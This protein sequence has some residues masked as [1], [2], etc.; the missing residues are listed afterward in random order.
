MSKVKAQISISLD[1][2]LAGLNDGREYPLGKG[3]PRLHQWVYDLLAWRKRQ[4][5][6]GGEDN[7]DSALVEQQV[8]NIGAVVMGRKM[9]DNG[10]EPW[11]DDPPFK[12]P[13][14]VVTHHPKEALVKEGGTV[15][16][17]LS[18]GPEVALERAREVAGDQDVSV[19]GG[20]NL[21]QQF[22][23]AGLLE[24]LQIHIAPELLGDGTRLFDGPGLGRIK[25]EKINGLDSPRVTHIG[26]RL[27]YPV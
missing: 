18:E 8:S 27:R 14:F 6:P 22:M 2:Y 11:G 1:G 17:F 15:F 26:Y 20:A 4:G 3:G 25:L 7:A 5:L 24:E 23:R 9:Y 21:L 12:V 13:V 16:H 19:A 10:E